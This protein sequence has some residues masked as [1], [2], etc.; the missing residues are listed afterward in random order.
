MVL[1]SLVLLT[2]RIVDA[3]DIIQWDKPINLSNTAT[4][5]HHPAI[6]ADEFGNVHI[7]WSEDVG[8]EPFLEGLSGNSIMYT[9]W[10][11]ERWTF[12]RDVLSVRGE[13]LARY[14]SVDIDESG[15]LHAVW[16]GQRDFYYS[17]AN[18]W[19]AE[20]P[21]AWS[22][23]IAVAGNNARTLREPGIVVDEAGVIHIIYAARGSLEGVYHIS[24]SYGIRI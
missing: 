3:Q 12:P 5:S 14:V 4:S 19:E 22:Q 20:S 16:G 7:F 24:P 1:V 23:P 11:G 13:N 18:G 6:V 8:G 10:D 21:K 17:S 15:I 2:L 9:R